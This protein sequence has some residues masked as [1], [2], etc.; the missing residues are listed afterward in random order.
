MQDFGLAIV[1]K[2]MQDKWTRERMR[3]LIP[4][5]PKCPQPIADA[6]ST[7]KLITCY[8]QFGYV[9]D[10]FAM[11][12][13]EFMDASRRIVKRHH[14][15]Y[16]LIQKVRFAFESKP[17]VIKKME[18][19]GSTDCTQFWDR[20]EDVL[21]YG[22]ASAPTNMDKYEEACKHFLASV[23]ENQLVQLV[24]TPIKKTHLEKRKS[25]PEMLHWLY[26]QDTSEIRPLP[27][28]KKKTPNQ[29]PMKRMKK[30]ACLQH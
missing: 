8:A 5:L 16:A 1:L 14:D 18:Y 17:D 26:V 19:I 27:S 30:W 28:P 2:Q 22:R 3:Q 7:E 12:Q 20:L 25:K 11:L 24:D 29:P 15:E 9:R 4:Q 13:Q 6:H 23:Q 10:Y 21:L